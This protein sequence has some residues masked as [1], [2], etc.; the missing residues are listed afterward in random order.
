MPNMDGTGPAGNGRCR[1]FG[2]ESATSRFG[3]RRGRH[4]GSNQ[5]CDT[6]LSRDEEIAVIERQLAKLQSRIEQ[7]SQRNATNPQ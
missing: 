1:R 7:I 2:M 6:E 5:P 3:R 4:F